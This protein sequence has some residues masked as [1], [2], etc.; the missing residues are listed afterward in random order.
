VSPEQFRG[1]AR[2]HVKD[3]IS[4]ELMGKVADLIASAQK[5][6]REAGRRG[7]SPQQLAALCELVDVGNIGSG[8][9]G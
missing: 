4:F 9:D 6:F 5:T 1:E 2:P 7:V 8:S 3:S